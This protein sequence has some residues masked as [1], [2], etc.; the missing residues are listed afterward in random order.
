MVWP[1]P[2]VP[3]YVVT[4]IVALWSLVLAIFADIRHLV[5]ICPDDAFY[6]L[7][8]ARNAA[9]GRGFTFDQI[10]M[11]NGFQPLW[12]LTLTIPAHFVAINDCLFLRS[13]FVIQTGLLTIATLTFCAA[14]KRIYSE[15][16]VTLIGLCALELLFLRAYNCMEWSIAVAAFA[17]TFYYVITREVFTTKSLGPI[18][19]FGI[20]LGFT[21][22]ARLDNIFILAGVTIVL[23]LQE[24]LKSNYGRLLLKFCL[25][26]IGTGTII[27]PYLVFNYYMFGHFMPISGA[28]KNSFPYLSFPYDLFIRFGRDAVAVLIA[29]V[30][31]GGYSFF[32]LKDSIS[33][34]SASVARTNFFFFFTALFIA[35]A[36]HTL[37]VLFYMK[38]A[39]FGWHF[40]LCRVFLVLAL[41]EPLNWLLSRHIHQDRL[42]RVYCLLS[43]GLVL[44]LLATMLKSYYSPQL[45]DSFRMNSYQAAM[46]AHKN[47]QDNEILAMKDAGV[48]G[49]FSRRKVVNLDGLVNDFTFQRIVS[50]GKLD[51]YLHA[52]GVRYLV[53]HA[54][55]DR[56]DV[57][58]GN[59]LHLTIDYPSH[60]YPE[61]FSQLTM[62]KCDEVYRSSPYFD[63]G[64]RTVFLIW[65]LARSIP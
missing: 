54:I 58:T 8:I 43:G 33:E 55:W 30:F 51:A 12:M 16:T 10:N 5:A 18:F 17:T 62:Q 40:V 9:A 49:Y 4:G 29:A 36:L 2:M 34:K 44:I 56:D 28:L 20:L 42:S 27:A 41:C 25:I 21:I 19:F 53:Q 32:T 45:A 31:A 37:N 50:D 63:G 14:L 64:Y 22:L 26:T 3:F 52:L 11:T 35:T 57:T 65:S 61:G 59:Y 1:K 47:L 6:Y 13:A 48:F 7:T 39:I 23:M 15:F 38:W 46:W 24:P 60:L